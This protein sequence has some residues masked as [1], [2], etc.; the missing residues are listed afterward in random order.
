MRGGVLVAAGVSMLL[1]GCSTL[2]G[3]TR[4]FSHCPERGPV[5]DSRI[6]VEPV[7]I[8]AFYRRLE[9]VTRG[10]PF[11]ELGRVR[12]GQFEVPMLRVGPLG[13]EAGRRVLVV[14]GTH[15]GEVAATLA[16][17]AV[18]ADVRRD[19]EA[20]KGAEI[21]VVVPANPAGF[22]VQ[23]RWNEKGC[24]IERDFEAFRTF[25]AQAIRIVIDRLDPQIVVDLH[26]SDREGVAVLATARFP[27]AMLEA[28]VDELDRKARKAGQPPAEAERAGWFGTGSRL[29]DYVEET[30]GAGLRTDTPWRDPDL[31]NRIRSQLV[32]VRAAVQSLTRRTTALR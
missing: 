30:G 28:V 23:S 27:D 12:S 31:R 4:P 19:P 16:G 10:V 5:P 1:A 20:W 29:V 11:R 18:V 14:A 15:G 13:T 22:A 3:M 7:Q 21:H 8:E 32:A 17:L 6:N 9:G 25:E 24:D 2:G 26:E